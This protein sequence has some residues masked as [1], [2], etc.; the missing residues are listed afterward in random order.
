MALSINMA[1]AS[2]PDPTRVALCLEDSIVSL[3]C[4]GMVH[5]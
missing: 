2:V 5:G 3:V 1:K 4:E